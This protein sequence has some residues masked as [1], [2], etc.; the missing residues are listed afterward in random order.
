M[1][2]GKRGKPHVSNEPGR[3][4]LLV[5]LAHR[6]PTVWQQV[7]GDR[8]AICELIA[9]QCH[10]RSQHVPNAVI[11]EDVT[12]TRLTHG[13][14]THLAL[15]IVGYHYFASLR[16]ASR[17]EMRSEVLF[18]VLVQAWRARIARPR[19]GRR[20]SQHMHVDRI[21]C[22]NLRK[23]QVHEVVRN[24]LANAGSVG[25]FLRDRSVLSRLASQ[26]GV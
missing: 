19:R 14:A 17:Q 5:E 15:V 9:F 2:Q 23:R 21:S 8:V 16:S 1:P 12:L 26:C 20:E 22:A 3:S 10:N 24:H 7:E 18:T 25:N 13:K 6:L 11:V 4:K